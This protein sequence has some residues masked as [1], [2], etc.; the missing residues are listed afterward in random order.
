V[1]REPLTRFF[2]RQLADRTAPSLLHMSGR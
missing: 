2:E 1:H